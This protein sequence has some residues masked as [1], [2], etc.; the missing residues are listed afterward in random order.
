MLS[1]WLK[2][3]EVISAHRIPRFSKHWLMVF[4]DAKKWSKEKLASRLEHGAEVV[5]AVYR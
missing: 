2:E 3:S 5:K 4:A 1:F